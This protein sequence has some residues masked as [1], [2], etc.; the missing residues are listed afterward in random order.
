MH[1][2]LTCRMP[3]GFKYQTPFAIRQGRLVSRDAEL[4]SADQIDDY[5]KDQADG[6]TPEKD[7]AVIFV[8][9]VTHVF[10]CEV[11]VICAFTKAYLAKGR[12]ATG[13]QAA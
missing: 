1:K 11:I 10:P 9:G 5:G 8:V 4:L 7:T 12:F 3:A 6:E 13:V 2:R